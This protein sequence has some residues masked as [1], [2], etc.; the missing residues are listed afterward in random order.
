MEERQKIVLVV[1][2]QDDERIIQGAMLGHLGYGVREASSGPAGLQTA[3]DAPPD[4]ILLDIAMPQMDGLTVCRELR[5]HPSTRAI[6]I[7][8]F[9]ASTVEEIRE[10]ADAVGASGVLT[11]PVDPHLVASEVQ[12]LIGPPRE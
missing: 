4:L 8:L 6:P 11:K 2:D 9:T 1:D 3:L 7:L 12:R 10:H 5:A